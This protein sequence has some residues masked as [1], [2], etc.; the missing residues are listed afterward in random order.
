M[1]ENGGWKYTLQACGATQAPVN[2]QEMAILLEEMWK[3]A[4]SSTT[5]QSEDTIPARAP[6]ECATQIAGEIMAAVAT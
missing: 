2:S 1:R 5:H 3:S 4:D 6:G